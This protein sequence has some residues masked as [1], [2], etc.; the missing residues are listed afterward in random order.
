MNFTDHDLFDEGPVICFVWKIAPGWPVVSVTKNISQLGYVQADF[1]ANKSLFY[2]MIHPDDL[3]RVTNEVTHYQASDCIHFEQDYRIITKSGDVRWVHDKTMLKRDASGLATNA[4]GYLLDITERKVAEKDLIESREQYFQLFESN[5]AVELLIDPRSGKIINANMAAQRFYG[6]DKTEF[7]HLFISDI[8]TLSAENIRAE[9][10][11]AIAEKR[12]YFNF[13]HR[14]KN[15]EVRDVTVYSGPIRSG[16]REILYSIIHDITQQRQAEKALLDS[17]QKFRSFIETTSEGFLSLSGVLRID[18]ANSAFCQLL[19]YPLSEIIGE[20]IFRFVVSESLKKV[21]KQLLH[22]VEEHQSGDLTLQHKNGQKISIHYKATSRGEGK[23]SFTFITDITKQKANEIKLKKL[24]SA[25]KHSASSIIITDKHGVIEYVNPRFCEVTG[26]KEAEAVGQTPNLISTK[27][28]PTA[29]HQELWKTILRGDDWHGETYNR[30]KS[31]SFYWSMMSISPIIDDDGQ[32]CNFISVSEDITEQKFELQKME[33]LALHDPL[34]GLAN[35]RLFDDRLY[36]AT[37]IISRRRHSGVGVVMLD[38]D[39]FK[40]INDTYGHDAGDALLKEV[41]RRLLSCTRSEDTVSRAGGDEFTLLIQ[42][43]NTINDIQSVTQKI[44]QSLRQ[45]IVVADFRFSITCSIGVC[46]ASYDSHDP[47]Q[48][49]KNADK[50]LYSAKDS[51]RNRVHF[52][53]KKTINLITER[54]FT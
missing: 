32:I 14:L 51:G 40:N 54:E 7:E 25:V 16:D 48:L 19:G 47:T 6:Y 12:D 45:P 3:S 9:M 37:Q 34:T 21:K 43:V 41:A 11:L 33:R 30:T 53:N 28:T 31:G 13:Q 22:C 20:S 26:F 39:H 50:A 29:L 44:L 5:K 18:F 8:N 24:S 15:G 17:E 2:E 52:F 23:G 38:L 36:Q 10:A 49:M 35:R 42:E 27:E 46:I 4:K 1:H